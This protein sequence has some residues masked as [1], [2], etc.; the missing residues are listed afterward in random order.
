MTLFMCPSARPGPAAT[1]PLAL[2]PRTG[3]CSPGYTCAPLPT[4]GYSGKAWPRT[5]WGGTVTSMADREGW[6]AGDVTGM[7]ANPFYAITID[8][9]LCLPHEP[10][11]SE[12]EWI[13]ANA[14]LISELGPE[15]YL[16]NLLSVL[17]GNYPRG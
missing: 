12:D 11:I 13:K 7:I 5:D 17:K 14:K 9:G 10:M 2:S 3:M 16:R 8:E 4:L 6:T 15:P 1:A